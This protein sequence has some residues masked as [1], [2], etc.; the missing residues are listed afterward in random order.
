MNDLRVLIVDDS[1]TDVF[2]VL[3]DLNRSFDRVDSARVW[4]ADALRQELASQAWDLVISELQLVSLSCTDA[5]EIVRRFDPHLPFIVVSWTLS[6][7][8]AVDLVRAGVND[9]VKKQRLQ[10]LTIA[11]TR[12][13]REA[14]AA[15]ETDR[16]SRELELSERRFR[17]TFERAP[18]GIANASPSGQLLRV[19]ERFAEILGY[20][21]SDL[22][23]RQIQ[24][25]SHPDD[26]QRG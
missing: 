16:L 18:I 5:L 2:V 17:A 13:L 11:V 26:R 1:E 24:E 23:G 9:C 21:A 14:A 19:N 25:F 12:E 8:G 4:T 20:S 15:R 22:I 6:E 3:K 10:R 7:E